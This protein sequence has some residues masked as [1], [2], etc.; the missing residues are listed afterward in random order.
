[1]QLSDEEVL[2]L[3]NEKN[4]FDIWSG[5]YCIERDDS[6]AVFCGARNARGF[7]RSASSPSCSRPWLMTDT[8]VYLLLEGMRPLL[9]EP[10]ADQFSGS[11]GWDAGTSALSGALQL[12]NPHSGTGVFVWR[13]AAKQ[14]L[15]AFLLHNGVAMNT[16]LAIPGIEIW[17]TW[18]A[19]GN[20]Y[21]GGNW[22]RN[23][24]YESTKPAI[25]RLNITDK[26]I[27]IKIFDPAELAQKINKKLCQ[28]KFLYQNSNFSSC[29]IRDSFTCLG[30]RFLIIA[31]PH[32]FGFD[33]PIEPASSHE[34][35]GFGVFEQDGEGN[36]ELIELCVD[37][38]LNQPPDEFATP[39]EQYYGLI[40]QQ[41]GVVKIYSGVRRFSPE[42]RSAK[43]MLGD[44]VC[45]IFRM[46]SDTAN[47]SLER[48]SLKFEG[49][50]PNSEILGMDLRAAP[51]SNDY[52]GMLVLPPQQRVRPKSEFLVSED[53]V[54][55]SHIEIANVNF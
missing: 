50:S 28:N 53:G 18:N 27:K 40:A 32:E 20:I 54:A 42:T 4:I 10:P 39:A 19:D 36:L 1:M 6:A 17:T 26:E 29:V 25:L 21:I 44:T 16:N 24:E 43:N 3:L 11:Y 9:I 49:I 51:D 37:H 46:A 22:L 23:T 52:Y 8:N 35:G 47:P 13:L 15:R 33:E 2:K 48:H 34:W 5:F 55:W 41:D 30:K 45:R 7:F 12:T 38:M 14:E 31:F